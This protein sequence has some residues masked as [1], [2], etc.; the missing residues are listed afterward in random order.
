LSVSI[1]GNDA[2]SFVDTTPSTLSSP[3]A[4]A[5]TKTRSMRP[6]QMECPDETATGPKADY[7]RE[8]SGGKQESGDGSGGQ[9]GPSPPKNP[10]WQSPGP[11]EKGGGSG[12]S[13]SDG[14]SGSTWWNMIPCPPPLIQWPI[15]VTAML[16][17]IYALVKKVFGCALRHLG[18]G[19]NSRKWHLLERWVNSRKRGGQSLKAFEVTVR[20]KY[21]KIY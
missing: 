6:A 9:S 16:W 3:T 11:T 18:Y 5:T 15:C 14:T 8:H 4:T 1:A 20:K 17:G 19:H 13:S 21:L 10:Y 12:G 7:H 2:S